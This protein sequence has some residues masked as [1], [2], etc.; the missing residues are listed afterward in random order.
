ML[1][2][3]VAGLTP[4]QIA[5]VMAMFILTLIGALALAAAFRWWNARGSG[6]QQAQGV[7]PHAMEGAAFGA[8]C[9]PL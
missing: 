8:R 3:H 6:I 5:A 9:L 2:S 4:T 7:N 1:R